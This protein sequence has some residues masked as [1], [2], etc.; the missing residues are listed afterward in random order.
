MTQ[1]LRGRKRK[2]PKTEEESMA[3]F[4]APVS[5]QQILNKWLKKNLKHRK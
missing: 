5:N 3:K 1:S 2:I 4:Y